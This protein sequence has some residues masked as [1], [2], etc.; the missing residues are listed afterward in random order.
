MPDWLTI[1][2]AIIGLIG[3]V[4]GVLGVS[5]YL[6]E[7]AKFKAEK[8]NKKEE[9]TEM[10]LEQLHVKQMEDTFRSV[11]REESQGIRDELSKINNEIVEIKEDLSANT[12]GTVTILRDRMKAILD[13]CRNAGYATTS[14]KGNWHEL[15][16]TY[17]SL[18]GNHFKEYV[19]AWK[20]ELEGLP[21]VPPEPVKVRGRRVST[22]IEGIMPVDASVKNKK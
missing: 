18:G 4:L 10:E 3:T 17:K 22:S 19:D 9:K 12:V 11:Y 14:T 15:Y 13:E 2:I 7:R 6:G 16:N 20:T 1:V 8:K 5:G 21:S